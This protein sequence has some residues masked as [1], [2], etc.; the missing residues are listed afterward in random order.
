V[1]SVLGVRSASPLVQ[2]GHYP[3]FDITP[4][5]FVTRIATDR[6]VFEPGRV[7]EYH[8]AERP[9]EAEPAAR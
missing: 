2:R 8:A 4:P 6:G 9:A 3:A 5:E 7:A 1:L